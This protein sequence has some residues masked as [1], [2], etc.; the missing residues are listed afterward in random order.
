M[1]TDPARVEQLFN[2]A[3]ERANHI[4]RHVF[5]TAA[6]GNDTALWNEVWDRL[7]SHP[8]TSGKQRKTRG[9]RVP[10][11]PSPN[12]TQEKPGD[13]IGPYKLLQII[14][15]SACSEMWMA[16][17]NQRVAEFVAIKIVPAA[18]NDFLIRYEAQKHSLA[19]LD[20]PRIAKPHACGMT[21]GGRPYLVTDLLYGTPITQFCDDQ[22]VSLLMR[23]RLFLQ[24]C[25][26][27]HHAHQTRDVVR[28]FRATAIAF[29]IHKRKVILEA[30]ARTDRSGC[31][32]NRR[33][34]I[35]FGVAFSIVRNQEC[36]AV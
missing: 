35:R 19:L 21:P 16:E 10:K 1:I 26:A 34:A 14:E 33:Q 18:A 30:D 24:A 28:Q 12:A 29:I 8:G 25:D 3:L 22:K 36:A 5:L 23:V 17:R 6:C 9:I 11:S 27:I 32:Q 31:P 4:E 15:E 2:E 7:R 13:L 20:H